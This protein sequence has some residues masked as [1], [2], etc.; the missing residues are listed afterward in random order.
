MAPFTISRPIAELGPVGQGGRTPLDEGLKKVYRG[1]PKEL[2]GMGNKDVRT[3]S[4]PRNLKVSLSMRSIK[5]RR[6]KPWR[7]SPYV[8]ITWSGLEARFRENMNGSDLAYAQHRMRRSIVVSI[9]WNVLEARSDENLNG[10]GS[11]ATNVGSEAV[12]PQQSTTGKAGLSSLGL[13]RYIY[14]VDKLY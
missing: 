3:E 12:S 9:T 4:N 14:C 1:R 11:V 8:S 2:V 10:L 5:N 13:P 7:R 6:I